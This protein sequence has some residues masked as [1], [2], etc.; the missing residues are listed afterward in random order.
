MTVCMEKDTNVKRLRV[1]FDADDEVVRRAIYIAAAMNNQTHNEV[2]NGLVR[3]HL[4]EF[5]ALAKKAIEREDG[6]PRRK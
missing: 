3:E 1:S 2:L 6:P 5:M 4:A